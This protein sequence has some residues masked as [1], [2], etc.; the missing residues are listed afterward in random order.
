MA[1]DSVVRTSGKAIA[2]L[3]FGL[4]AFC[5]PLLAGLVGVILGFLSLGEIKRG[6]GR[7][8]GK[9]LAVGGILASFLGT[10]FSCGVLFVYGGFK[11][12]EAVQRATQA[13]RTA[14]NLKQIGLAMHNYH[15]ATGTLPSA[16]NRGPNS[17]AGLSWRVHLLPYLEQSPLYLQFRQNEPWDSPHN[18]TLL[19]MMPSVYTRSANSDGLTTTPFQVF[20]GPGTA[21]EAGPDPIRIPGSIT[22]GTSNTLMVVEARNE[23]PWTKPEDLP[24]DPSRPLPLLGVAGRSDFFVMTCDSAVHRISSSTDE[25]TLKAMITRNGKESINM[26]W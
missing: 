4:L 14:N 23:V 15:D 5:V 12:L 11:S 17:S 3:I 13:A 20:V 18:K 22:D 21:F 25:K 26:P 16:V 8:G 24:F 1:T 9:G 10:L 19:A 7:V 2:S 6:E